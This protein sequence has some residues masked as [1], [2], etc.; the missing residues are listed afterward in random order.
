MGNTE[1][2]TLVIIFVFFTFNVYRMKKGSS[3]PSEI[4]Q[5]IPNLLRKGELVGIDVRSPG[6]FSHTSPKQAKNI[7]LGDI[8]AKAKGL[9]KNKTYI[10]FCHSGARAGMAIGALKRNGIDK[11]YNLGT[12]RKWNEAIAQKS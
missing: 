7:P 6:E 4:Y 9:D 11:V 5:N 1:I 2:I 10:V 3:V 12:W 8:A